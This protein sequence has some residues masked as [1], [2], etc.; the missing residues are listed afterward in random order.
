MHL[1]HLAR[2][3]CPLCASPLAVASA[4]DL[5]DEVLWWGLLG[6]GCR[7]AHAVVD[8]IALLVHAMDPRGAEARARL[9]AGREGLPGWLTEVRQRW[10]LGLPS[11][12]PRDTGLAAI[13]DAGGGDFYDYFAWK[14]ATRSFATG[15]ALLGAAP[16]GLLVDV[17][18]GL[19]HLSWARARLS[20]G[21]PIVA[22]DNCL[23]FL[24]AGRALGLLP[25]PPS[26]AL[27]C[28]DANLGLPVADGAAAAVLVSDGLHYF[29]RPS[30]VLA[31]ARRALGAHGVLVLNHL[32]NAEQ[33]AD[34]PQQGRS[35]PV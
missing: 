24:Q 21:D 3:R 15:V 34:E 20:P 31:G 12:A 4:V 14:W 22:I 27:V 13:A 25:P 35:L 7:E 1:A 11:L 8:G 6:C 17:A 28:A 23:T 5:R 19:G 16:P 32:H 10:A 18:C 29:V 30:R 33:A 26:G 9:A 2:L